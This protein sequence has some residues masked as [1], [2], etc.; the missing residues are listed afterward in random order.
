[1]SID[2]GASGRTTKLIGIVGNPVGHS[3]SPNIHNRAF[4]A[5]DLDFV[6]LKFPAPDRQDFLRKRAG[7]RNL[8]DFQ[9]RFRIR[10]AVIPFLDDMTPEAREAGAVNTVRRR[11]AN[12]LATTLMFMAFGRRSASAGFD[13]V[14]KTVV[15]LGA[16]GAAKA[17]VVAL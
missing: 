3:L 2:S 6:Y 16:G 8:Q 15:I 9:S 5:L 7:D 4:E 17:A 13:P 11:T 12:G 10:R 14:D 1:M